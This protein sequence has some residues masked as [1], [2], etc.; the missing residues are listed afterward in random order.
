[1][2]DS[3][4]CVTLRGF[5]RN[6]FLRPDEDTSSPWYIHMT[7]K[8]AE[9]FPTTA[10]AK[11]TAVSVIIWGIANFT[12]TL[13]TPIMFNN[14]SFWIF[15]VFAISNLFAGWWTGRYQPETG[16]RSFEDN[17]RFFKEAKKEG[18]WAVKRVAEGE[19][20]TMPRPSDGS[21]ESEPLLRRVREQI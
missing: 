21:G 16:G 9:I 7:D 19:W 6:L 15:L 8:N 12:V 4:R 3:Y 14:L 13:L 1:M 10:R 18:S 20:L 2:A 17:Q 5:L 11:G